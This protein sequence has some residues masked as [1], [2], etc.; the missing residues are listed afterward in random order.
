MSYQ[1]TKT[2]GGTLNTYHYMK[3]VNLKI[4]HTVMDTQWIFRAVKLFC[5][6]HNGRYIVS[7][8]MEYTTQGV[9][10]DV[11]YGLQLVTY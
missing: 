5:M 4:F 3:E 2:L 1:V 9:N 10:P 11:N 7:K 6:I 8:L